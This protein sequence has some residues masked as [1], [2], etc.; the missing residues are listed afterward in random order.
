MKENKKITEIDRYAIDRVDKA[1]TWRMDIKNLTYNIANDS[2]K[3]LII[4]NGGTIPIL[5]TLKS[6]SPNTEI[7]GLMP[8]IVIFMFGLISA[9]LAQFS[10]YKS[11]S[12]QG[13]NLDTTT[14]DF[15]D[16]YRASRESG[17]ETIPPQS[18]EK[19]SN[20]T[21]S[22]KS[23]EGK[24]DQYA[25]Y[26]ATASLLLFIIG[27]LFSMCAFYSAAPSSP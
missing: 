26:F 19:K 17:H 22:S 24:W 13:R 12:I 2:F 1:Q 15:I 14:N 23:K 10:I 25:G 27:G 3:S 7:Q 9:L 16:T 8:P 21:S 4:L 20:V 6:I 18:A 5:A 11:L